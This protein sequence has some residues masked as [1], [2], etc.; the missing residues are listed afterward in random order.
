[1][2]LSTRVILFGLF[3]LGTTLLPTAVSAQPVPVRVVVNDEGSLYIVRGGYGWPLVPSPLDE[4]NPPAPA[5]ALRD[6]GDEID[7]TIAPPVAFTPGDVGIVQSGAVDVLPDGSLYLLRSGAAYPLVPDAM[8]DADV[9]ALTLGD[10][11][12]GILPR[13]LWTDQQST[14]QQTQ[15]RSSPATPTAASIVPA[16]TGGRATSAVTP[17]PAD[18]GQFVGTWQGHAR[19]IEVHSDGTGTL[20]WSYTDRPDLRLGFKLAAVAEHTASG[21]VTTSNSAVHPVG[22]SVTLT[23]NPDDTLTPALGAEELFIFCG[24]DTP[25]GYCGA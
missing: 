10:Q 20:L 13:E 7:G 24:P 19:Q 17:S 2:N 16:S 11:I 15:Q 23:L 18:F 6:I 5:P 9:T 1:M 4:L 3:A 14:A 22:Q 25:A 12:D 21:Q 8:S